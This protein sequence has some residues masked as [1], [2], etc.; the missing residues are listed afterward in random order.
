MR[1]T[2]TDPANYQF[3]SQNVRT[4]QLAADISLVQ[5]SP[6]D[7]FTEVVFGDEKGE[8]RAVYDFSMCNPPFFTDERQTDEGRIWVYFEEYFNN[9]Y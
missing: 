5:V 6:T 2:E 7:I 1:A 4:N 9:W 3:A 8:C